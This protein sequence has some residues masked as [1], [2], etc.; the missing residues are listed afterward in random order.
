[1]TYDTSDQH[2]LPVQ[3]NPPGPGQKGPE[4]LYPAPS[5]LDGGCTSYYVITYEALESDDGAGW[6]AESVSDS[7]TSSACPDCN[8]AGSV[9]LLVSR[10]TCKTCGGTGRGG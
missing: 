7:E 6:P 1:M 8:G 3:Y 2:H 5:G 4:T 9:L 10:R